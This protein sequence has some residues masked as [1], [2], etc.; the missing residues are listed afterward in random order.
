MWC[1]VL[2]R[3]GADPR[4][5]LLRLHGVGHPDRVTPSSRHQPHVGLS[6]AIGLEDDPPAVGGPGWGVV[7][8]DVVGEL[9]YRAID[10]PDQHIGSTAPGGLDQEFAT[11]G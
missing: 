8:V 5:L 3:G 1:G 6:T 7:T 2:D 9:A 11:V 4:N 10:A